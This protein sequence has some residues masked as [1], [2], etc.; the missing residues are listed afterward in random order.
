[1]NVHV[2][3]KA[4]KT[5]DVEKEIQHFIHKLQ[6][7]LQV[8]RPELIHLKGSVDECSP[9]EGFVVAL[10]LR[11]PSGQMAAQEAA[12][13]AAGAVKSAFDD[14]LE[15]INKHK[16]HLRSSQ[17]SRRRKV[18]AARQNPRV[19]FEK[20]LAA[21]H[22]AAVSADDV[23]SYVNA[24]LGRLQRFVEREIFFRE[25]AENVPAGALAS[26]EVIDEAIVRALD[27]GDKPERLAL[28]PWLYRLALRAMDDLSTVDG[29]GN[30][31]VHLEESARKQNVKASDE[32]ELQFHQPDE[33]F[34][35]ES[36]IADR[37]VATPEELA[38]SDEMLSLIQF[39]LRGLRAA[40]R[41]AFILHAIE[42]FTVEE[43][44]A[45]TDRSS[46]E[47]QSSIALAQEHLRMAT[48]VGKGQP[49]QRAR[50]N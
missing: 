34:T 17:K 39:A 1:M 9:R 33:S 38:Y 24:N 8:F 47:V 43:I 4:R 6:R 37:R 36:V 3:Y 35:E 46:T 49:A 25:D 23:R 42:G 10:N 14:L 48:P 21:V 41:E 15:Q 50:A 22:P 30:G 20:T 32:A 40:D 29:D 44:A 11:L 2:S 45:I 13:T 26:S 19:P 7:R 28:E 16:A 5:S 31:N 27:D 18:V 12:P